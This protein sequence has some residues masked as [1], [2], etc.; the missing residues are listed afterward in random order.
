MRVMRKLPVVPV[1]RNRCILIYGN[2][3]DDDPKSE[4][5]SARPDPARGADRE[6]SRNAGLDAMDVSALRATCRADERR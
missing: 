6:S 2:E 1:C 5:L 3:L 4:A